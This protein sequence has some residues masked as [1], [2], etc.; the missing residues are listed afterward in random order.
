ATVEDLEITFMSE[1][2]YD[3]L[4]YTKE[5]VLSEP[6]FWRSHLHSED[7]ADVIRQTFAQIKACKPFS[8]QYRMLR[9]DGSYAWVLD[10]FSVYCVDG[11]PKQ[12][13]GLL[14]DVTATKLLTDL[15]HLEKT[16]LELHSSSNVP[17]DEVLEYYVKGIEELF[18]QM[19]CAI[20]KIK[21]G[22]VHKWVSLSLPPAYE[23][24]IE[25]HSIGEKAGS[26][27]TAA[28]RKEM[29]IVSDIA[30]DPLWEHYREGALKEGLHACWSYPIISSGGE[31]LASLAMYYSSVN[32]PT[33]EELRVIERTASI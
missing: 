19:I 29:V 6:E 7:K 33:V 13:R 25:G 17:L 1:R 21:H 9:K 30:T 4:G 22:R 26:C 3:I 23:A 18:P 28:F 12:L 11:E 14:I 2:V 16:V 20:M 27:G 5:E 8:F 24:S 32:E 31:V 15:E 10:S